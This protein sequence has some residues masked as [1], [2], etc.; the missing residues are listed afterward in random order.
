MTFLIH[1]C[2][3]VPRLFEHLS[4]SFQLLNVNDTFTITSQLRQISNNFYKAPDNWCDSTL[5]QLLKHNQNFLM[6]EA[7]FSAPTHSFMMEK[8]PPEKLHHKKTYFLNALDCK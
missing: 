2:N 3:K 8:D 7:S 6:T 5:R 4:P 1:Y